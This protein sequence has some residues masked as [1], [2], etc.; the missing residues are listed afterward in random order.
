MSKR[1]SALLQSI[2]EAQEAE[3]I[4]NTPQHEKQDEAGENTPIPSP[5]PVLPSKQNRQKE[6]KVNLQKVTCYLR[7]DQVE[8]WDEMT[9]EIRLKIKK[10]KLEYKDIDRQII[11]RE[12]FD[13]I[14]RD[15]IE[16]LLTAKRSNGRTV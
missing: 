9:E 2:A 15:Q 1:P 13:T 16:Q 5:T 11:L 10:K 7:L 8:F 6:K 14:N 3:K 4:K 12:I